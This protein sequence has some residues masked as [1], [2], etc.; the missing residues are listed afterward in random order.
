MASKKAFGKGLFQSSDPL[1]IFKLWKA[2]C[3]GAGEQEAFTFSAGKADI[4][5]VGVSR[6]WPAVSLP[7]CESQLFHFLAE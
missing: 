5:V 3:D 1:G 2:D 4:C 7:G 6:L